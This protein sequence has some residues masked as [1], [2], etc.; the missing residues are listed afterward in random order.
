V[1]IVLDTNVLIS[2]LLNPNGPP[3]MVLN[4]I[5][6]EKVTLLMD[7][8]IYSEYAEVL[9]RPK[10]K[11]KDEWINPLLDFIRMEGEFI[12]PEP[13]SIEFLDTDDIVFYEIAKSGKAIY[14]VTGN[15]KHFPKDEIIKTP[16]EFLEEYS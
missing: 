8:R 12:L 11:F 1:K 6:N 14:L 15:I 3:A 7:S 5:V 4:L 16:K 9:R 10:F 13:C 2:G